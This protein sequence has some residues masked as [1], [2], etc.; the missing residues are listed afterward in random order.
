M[1]R[2]E[3]LGLALA[4]MSASIVL[5]LLLAWAVARD[6]RVIGLTE[7]AR[8]CWILAAFFFGLVAYITYRL[9]R[10]KVT[11]VTCVNCGLRRRPD[12]EKC[13]HC[14]SGWHVPEITPPDW[15]VV[16]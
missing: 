14:G 13:H 1:N 4:L 10:P 9:A 11:L 2:A 7:N 3:R 16:D 12:M 6:A 15:R 5:T 8:L